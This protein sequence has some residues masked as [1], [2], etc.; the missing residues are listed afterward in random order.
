[1]GEDNTES[2]D[3]RHDQRPIGN[4]TDTISQVMHSAEGHWVTNI[5]NLFS[6]YPFLWLL[7]ENSYSVQQS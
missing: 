1:M 3:L 5:C 4:T 6:Y 2:A 7:S